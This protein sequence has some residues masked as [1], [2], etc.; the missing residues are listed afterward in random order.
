[1]GR[2]HGSPQQIAHAPW[3]AGNAI[4]EFLVHYHVDWLKEQVSHHNGRT[5]QDRRFWYAPGTDQLVYGIM[6]VGVL[7]LSVRAQR[8]D[9]ASGG[10][11][12]VGK[13]PDNQLFA[14]GGRQS[15]SSPLYW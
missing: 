4:G 11:E 2:Q 7:D 1:L 13:E 10:F 9:F 6:I 12:L 14:E 5:A 3:L 15:G 8:R